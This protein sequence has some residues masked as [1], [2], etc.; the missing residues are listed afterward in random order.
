MT[1]TPKTTIWLVSWMYHDRSGSGFV[2][3]FD[4]EAKARDLFGLLIKHGGEK[5]YCIDEIQIEREYD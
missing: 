2:R 5:A 3:A 4:S 1:E